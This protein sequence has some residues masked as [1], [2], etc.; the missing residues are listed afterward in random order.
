MP[1]PKNAATDPYRA[2]DDDS[3]AVGAWRTRMGTDE[4][5]ERYKERAATAECVNAR[6]RQCGL[7]RLRVRGTDKARGVLPMYALVHNP[8]RTLALAPE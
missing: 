6:V 4:A 3:P 1:K 2:K 7:L 5:K 8:M